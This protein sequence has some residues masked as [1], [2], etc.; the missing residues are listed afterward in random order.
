MAIR[1]ELELKPQRG[2]LARS[3]FAALLLI[4]P[5]RRFHLFCPAGAAGSAPAI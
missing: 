5:L 3:V 1:N 2:K 4:L